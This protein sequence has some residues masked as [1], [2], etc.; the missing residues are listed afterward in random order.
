MAAVVVV[1]VVVAVVATI[2]VVLVALFHGNVAKM[3]T[4]EA[5][6]G[7]NTA[8]VVAVVEVAVAEVADE[9]EHHMAVVV[10]QLADLNLPLNLKSNWDW[11]WGYFDYSLLQQP[12]PD[13]DR[14]S[15]CTCSSSMCSPRNYHMSTV[16]QLLT[17]SYWQQ[18]L[19]ECL[20]LS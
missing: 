19:F 13:G 15:F 11:N 8:E 4:D 10:D 7:D 6:V 20:D 16:Q 1:V 2:A 18:P 5:V 12:P 17:V 9:Q 14:R 3:M